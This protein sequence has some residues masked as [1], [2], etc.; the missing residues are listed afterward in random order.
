VESSSSE[1]DLGLLK[2]ITIRD[3]T[4][5]AALYDRRS[6]LAYSVIMRILGSTSDAEDV[7]QETFVRVWLR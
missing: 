3:E 7:L 2:R 6:R 5:L 1:I 4:A